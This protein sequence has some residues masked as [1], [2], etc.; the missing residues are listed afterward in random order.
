MCDCRKVAIKHDPKKT[1]LT[2]AD[3]PTFG[4]GSADFSVE[5]GWPSGRGKPGGLGPSWGKFWALVSI[6]W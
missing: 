4:S 1:W 6:P 5:D 2:S 3:F